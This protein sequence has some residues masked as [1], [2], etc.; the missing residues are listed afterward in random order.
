[1]PIDQAVQALDI[2]RYW[3]FENQNHQ[4]LNEAIFA[5]WVCL[6]ATTLK[7]DKFINLIIDYLT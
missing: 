6:D 7:R 3:I 5:L 4:R 1:M 2:I